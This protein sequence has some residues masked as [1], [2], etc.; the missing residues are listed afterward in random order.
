MQL[1]PVVAHFGLEISD[2]DCTYTQPSIG[3]MQVGI[4][5]LLEDERLDEATFRVK[6]AIVDIR[7]AVQLPLRGFEIRSSFRVHSPDPTLN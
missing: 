5:C 7:D 6:P 4:P 1:W 3:L 2:G